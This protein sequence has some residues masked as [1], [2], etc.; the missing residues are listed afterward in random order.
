MPDIPLMLLTIEYA[1][2][3]RITDGASARLFGPE[4]DAIYFGDP[5]WLASHNP[6]I[7]SWIGCHEQ[8]SPVYKG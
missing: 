4:Y 2:R 5:L 6:R 3:L 1:I 7:L 8:K